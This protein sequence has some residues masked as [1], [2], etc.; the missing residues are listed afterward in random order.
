MDV[1]CS[2]RN[3][4][5]DSITEHLAAEYLRLGQ[6][7]S[8]WNSCGGAFPLCTLFRYHHN[9]HTDISA[10]GYVLALRVSY[11]HNPS[12]FVTKIIV[13]TNSGFSERKMSMI[14]SL[15]CCR[16]G[17]VNSLYAIFYCVHIGKCT[18]LLLNS[19]LFSN[20]IGHEET[21]P[22]YPLLMMVFGLVGL[23]LDVFCYLVIWDPDNTRHPDTFITVR[24]NKVQVRQTIDIFL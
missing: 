12:S 16:R 8:G 18:K 5:T 7:R 9:I 17:D 11:V 20:Q 19:K 15:T 23:T 1:T 10:R 3:L 4:T 21:A 22:H 6:N 2:H 14:S 24:G 13:M